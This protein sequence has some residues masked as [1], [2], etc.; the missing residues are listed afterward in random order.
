MTPSGAMVARFVSAGWSFVPGAAAS[1]PPVRGGSRRHADWRPSKR[2]LE[3]AMTLPLNLFLSLAVAASC[4]AANATD[5]DVRGVDFPGAANTAV[6]AINDSGNFVGAEK[7]AAGKHHA[8]IGNANALSLLGTNSPLGSA[9]ESWAFSINRHGDVAGAFTDAA[10]AKHG[11]V[12]RADGAFEMIDEPGA[13]ATQAYGI[14]ARGSVIGITS[15][16]DGANPHAYVLRNGQFQP[17]DLPGVAQ[18]FP[19][20]INEAEEIV[21]EAIQTDGTNGFGYLQGPRGRFTLVTA[22]GSAPEQTYFI[23][24]NDRNEV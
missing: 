5:Y 9:V 11:Y 3:P 23:S 22:P 24:I 10:G 12:L 16:S 1:V 13:A 14:N 7:D 15:D 17:A 8:I 4:G 21:G 2:P 6:Y 20:S 18:T 19:L